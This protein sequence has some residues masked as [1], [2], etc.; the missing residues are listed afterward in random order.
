MYT[1]VYRQTLL[2]YAM[3]ADSKMLYRLSFDVPSEPGHCP[4]RL[5][6]VLPKLRLATL[7]G[8]VLA[9]HSAVGNNLGC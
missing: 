6:F 4:E 2:S 1:L 5:S 3:Q 8:S 7:Y 9:P